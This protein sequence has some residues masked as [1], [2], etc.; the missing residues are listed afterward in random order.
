[1]ISAGPTHVRFRKVLVA[2]QVA[3]TVLLLAGACLFTRTLWNLRSQNLGFTTDNLITFSVQPQLNGYKAERNVALLDQIRQ[4]LAALPGVRS[5][6]SSEIAVLTGTDMGTNITVEG[7]NNVNHEDDQVTFEGVSANYFWTMGIPLLYGR[8]FRESDN[9]TSPKV[10]LINQ[11]MAEKFFPGRN[12]VGSHIGLG[13]SKMAPDIEI[14]GVIKDTQDDH[15]RTARHPYFYLPYS[16]AGVLFGLTFYV[17]PQQEP[18]NMTNNIRSA[19]K[20]QDLNLPVYD[21]KAVA[22]VVDE[23][24]FADRMVATLSAAFGGLA[25]MLA[26]LGIYG[27]LA[28]LVLQRTREIGIRIALGAGT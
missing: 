26:A 24:L 11:T 7:R 21:L 2:G 15:V 17:R 8:E 14:V 23:D 22:R 28:Y 27:V 12:A 25:A 1:S 4:R 20:E 13:G 3:F 6:V 19:V 9:A 18:F 16:Q 5:V 10:T